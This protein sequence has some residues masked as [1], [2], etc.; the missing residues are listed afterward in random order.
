MDV[1]WDN[2]MEPAL[3]AID[4][5]NLKDFH[6]V[7]KDIACHLERSYDYNFNLRILKTKNPT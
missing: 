2:N 7:A 1:V 5:S 6:V 3:W 4:L